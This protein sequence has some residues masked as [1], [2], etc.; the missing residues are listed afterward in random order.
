MAEYRISRNVEASIIDFIV[1]ELS[2]DS[3]TGI[4]VLKGF[5]EDYKGLTPFIGVEA[6]SRGTDQIEIGSNSIFLD[7][8]ISIR[9]FAVNDG[10]R[11]DLSD[12]LLDVQLLDNIDYYEY[13]IT[14]GVVS[15]KSK[16]G[17][18]RFLNK[19]SRKELTNTQ[20]LV[21]EDRY[22]QLITATCRVT[23]D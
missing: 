6:L 13:T 10:Q 18:I 17:K 3:W 20:T 15:E 7:I 4:N 23:L 8:P 22:R 21:A 16:V 9:I 14:N 1:T 12:W 2:S 19:V 11:L 5:P